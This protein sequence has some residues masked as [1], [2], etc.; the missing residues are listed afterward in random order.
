M[1]NITN[2]RA[3]RLWQQEFERQM[4]VLENIF[5][6][7]LR[8][9]L[10]RQYM[11]AATLVQQ[12]VLDAVDHSVDL[13]RARLAKIFGRHYKRVAT[14]FGNKTYSIMEDVKSLVAYESK[15]PKDEFWK[16][17]NA[18][19]SSQT[20]QKVRRVQK[21][22]KENIARVIQKGMGEGEDHR[23][24]AKRVRKQS[25]AVNPHRA[26]TIALTET[27]SVAVKSMDTAIASTRIEME[28]EWVSAKDDRTR[29]RARK[30]KFE[31][32][33]KFPA[34]PDGE[35]TSQD[36]QFIKT[37]QALSFPG[38]PKGSA[39]NVV[40]CRCVLL[41]HTV[42][43]TDKLKPH[44]PTI[45]LTDPSE[46]IQV[47]NLKDGQKQMKQRFK[48]HKT[49]FKGYRKEKSSIDGMNKIG[50][51][52]A[53][54][55]KRNPGF[56]EI[57]RKSRKLDSL[58]I[59]NEKNLERLAGKPM[60]AW[61]RYWGGVAQP[62]RIELAGHHHSVSLLSS[63]ATGNSLLGGHSTSSAFNDPLVSL[64]HE[65]AHHYRTSGK[66]ISRKA[67]DVFF[68]KKGAS[69]FRKNVTKYS[70]TSSSEAFSDVMA[71]LLSPNYGQPGNRLPKELE[72]LLVD[73]LKGK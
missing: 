48:I 35:K 38:D 23:G 52:I 57:I 5:A 64:M 28:R 53:D 44:V 4:V 10:G 31:H 60:G 27:H 9:V 3:K 54:T 30:D 16:S 73:K 32:Y 65:L 26:R 70:G 67:W 42:K 14:T 15:G 19:T 59:F 39:G 33:L 6:R 34:G 21:T 17:I 49:T 51:H 37:G 25:K 45:D 8:P 24:I 50:R 2:T 41:Y 62:G 58:T 43:R 66:P 46:W 72:R 13:E 56:G 12:G 40:R 55:V 47:K 69:W 68:N 22:T 36:G 1:I 29:S 11:N 61:G 7:E 71:S 63:R 20:A 18:W